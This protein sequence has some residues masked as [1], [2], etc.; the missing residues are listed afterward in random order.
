MNWNREIVQILMSG[1]SQVFNVAVTAYVVRTVAKD[2]FDYL[3]HRLDVLGK[4]A[5]VFYPKDRYTESKSNVEV[6]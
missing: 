2:I 5:L 1:L 6:E 3:N 4:D